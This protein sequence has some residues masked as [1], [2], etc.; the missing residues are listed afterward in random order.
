MYE[1]IS[2]GDSEKFMSQDEVNCLNEMYN[3]PYFVKPTPEQTG[4][5]IYAVRKDSIDFCTKSYNFV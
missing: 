3:K 1:G 2:P 4:E 5:Y